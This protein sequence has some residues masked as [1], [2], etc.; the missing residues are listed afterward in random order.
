M[1]KKLNIRVGIDLGTTNSC[2]AL[3]KQDDLHVVPNSTGDFT[4][5]SVVYLGD[6]T[7]EFVVGDAAKAKLKALKTVRDV[8]YNSKRLLGLTYNEINFDD[9]QGADIINVNDYPIYQIEKDNSRYTPEQISGYVLKYLKKISE[10]YSDMVVKKGVIAV[11][12]Y[13]NEVQ[14][15]ATLKA[16]EIAGINVIRLINEPTACAIAYGDKHP[17]TN[18]TILVY[19]LGGGTFDVSLVR[20]E[21]QVYKVIGISGDRRLG[22]N[23]FDQR[24]L[25]YFLVQAEKYGI[26]VPEKK[27][28]N[29][30]LCLCKAKETLSSDNDADINFDPFDEIDDNEL[31][32][33]SRSLLNEINKDLFDRTIKII[34][35]LLREKAMKP[36]DINR[37][38]L[39]G[40]SSK[41]VYIKNQLNT[42]FTGK[43]VDT[44]E[45]LESECIVA[46]GACIVAY[47]SKEEI[48]TMI[49]DV[50]PRGFGVQVKKN[51]KYCLDLIANKFEQLPFETVRMYKTVSPD[52]DQ[53]VFTFYESDNEKIIKENH[54]GRFVIRIPKTGNITQYALFINYN[55]DGMLDIKATDGINESNLRISRLRQ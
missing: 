3:Y 50:I 14:R 47:K 38:I 19:D 16:A 48:K 29:L 39:A 25:D 32:V 9:V 41:I 6:K 44:I 15:G 2:C 12:A 54:M 18:E 7:N 23:D 4:T 36:K 20:K 5:P 43:V 55:V 13:F 22:G 51:G 49:Q 35:D 1:S 30:K 17:E 53:A 28:I 10:D 27:K 8:C 26:R 37:V 21:K 24:L 11:P 34:D 46:R 52:Q 42:M 31:K 33:L 40:G 45:G